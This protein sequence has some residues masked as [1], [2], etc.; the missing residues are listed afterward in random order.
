MC[1]S[2]RWPQIVDITKGIQTQTAECVVIGEILADRFLVVL[3]KVDLLPEENREKL[4]EK[5]IADLRK[6]L[7]KTKLGQ[8]DMIAVAARVGGETTVGQDRRATGLGESIG[9][10]ELVEKLSSMIQL[11]QRRVNVSQTLIIDWDTVYVV[12]W[13]QDHLCPSLRVGR[14]SLCD[15]SLLSGQGTGHSADRHGVIPSR[16]SECCWLVL[17]C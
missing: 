13:C 7:G 12:W 6:A 3:N 4:V 10:V 9:V 15:R 5:A 14:F 8:A 2:T 17:A 16:F 11:P 1:V